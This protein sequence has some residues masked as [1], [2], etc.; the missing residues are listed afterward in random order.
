MDPTTQ[1]CWAL[2]HLTVCIDV[3]V[4]ATSLPDS[5]GAVAHARLLH[6]CNSAVNTTQT[7]PQPSATL[8]RQHHGTPTPPS[9][10]MQPCVARTKPARQVAPQDTIQGIKPPLELNNI[11]WI[12]P[13]ATQTNTSATACRIESQ[14]PSRSAR[15]SGGRYI[16]E[17]GYFVVRARAATYQ[18]PAPGQ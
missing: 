15:A 13:H 1:H 7:P 6:P 4:R 17:G 14:R 9:A 5:E 18:R 8:A 16:H 2:Q 12:N 3:T 10:Q 11:I